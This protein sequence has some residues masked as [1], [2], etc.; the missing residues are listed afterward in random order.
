MVDFGIPHIVI[1]A[2]EYT[3]ELSLMH[4]ESVLQPETLIGIAHFPGMLWRDRRDVVCIDNTPLHE[5]YTEGIE[6]VPNF[7]IIEVILRPVKSSCGK[8]IHTSESLVFEIVNGITDSLVVHS[9]IFVDF[10]KHYGDKP[11][12]PVMAMYDIWPFIRLEHEF[13]CSF[14]E[15]CK[16]LVVIFG[17]IERVTIEKV[18]C[19]M[20]IY[21]KTPASVNLTVKNRAMY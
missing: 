10:V 9:I 2:V 18:V 13:E 20:R 14:T 1:N 4:L 19:R 5:I 12:L 3:P 11:G 16:A 6:V 17:S 8:Y 15:E 7:L 21:E